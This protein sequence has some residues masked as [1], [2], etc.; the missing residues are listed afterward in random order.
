M[1]VL[2]GMQEDLF[3]IARRA[4]CTLAP[5]LCNQT[6]GGGATPPY[7]PPINGG[8]GGGGGSGNA[9]T[10]SEIPWGKIAA[11]VAVTTA[12]GVGVWFATKKRSRR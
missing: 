8:G 2:R 6:G 9:S 4:G 5:A 3:E 1:V 10:D 7:V 11:A 12:L